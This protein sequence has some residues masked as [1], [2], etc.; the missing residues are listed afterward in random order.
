M[1]QS[2]N[3]HA[4]SVVA[5]YPY[6]DSIKH[7]R[8]GFYSE[9]PD[10]DFFKHV[11]TIYSKNHGFMHKGELCNGDRFPGGITNGAHWY[12]V[13]GGNI[14]ISIPTSS[15]SGRCSKQGAEIIFISQLLLPIE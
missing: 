12:D 6:D 11:A 10:D 15:D 1:L 7:Q 9:A 3:F 5:S 13:P 8:R 2:A 14:M 4:G